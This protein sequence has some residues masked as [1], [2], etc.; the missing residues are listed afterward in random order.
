MIL[1]YL[2]LKNFPPK[3]FGGHGKA[4]LKFVRVMNLL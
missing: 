1:V 3:R 2:T 4:R